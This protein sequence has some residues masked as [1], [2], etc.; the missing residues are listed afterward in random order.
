MPLPPQVKKLASY[1]YR[2]IPLPYHY[3]R[4]YREIAAFLDDTRG[5]SEERLQEYQLERVKHIVDHAYQNTRFY[6][7]LYDRVGYK[8]GDISTF[9][10]F[11]KLPTIDRSD[12]LARGEDF[13]ARDFESYQ[14]KLTYT[15][16]TSGAPL[17][18]YRSRDTELHRRASSWRW[19]RIGGTDHYRP[20]VDFAAGVD[21]PDD[22]QMFYW[23][24]RENIWHLN[25]KLR[26]RQHIT[27]IFQ[28]I[29]RI[30][31]AALTGAPSTIML[32]AQLAL[33]AGLPPYTS[34]AV[35]T[36]GELLKRTITDKIE[37][38]FGQTLRDA[39]GNRE[40]SLS[41][42][43]YEYGGD[44]FVNAE[45]CRVELL[46]ETGAVVG[47]GESGEVCST[48][49]INEAFP[50]IRYRTADIAEDRGVQQ[51]AGFNRRAI[52]PLVGRQRDIILTPDGLM[53]VNLIHNLGNFDMT[54]IRN[55]VI[56]QYTI[57]E[58]EVQLCPAPGFRQGD[59][60]AVFV[61]EMT[62]QL[63]DNMRFVVKYIDEL[64]ITNND[65]IKF[66]DSPLAREYLEKNR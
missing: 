52:K 43:Q 63:P 46:D 38:F 60:E 18:I 2:A 62:R 48:S 47:P 24:A 42:Y 66:V 8:P 12:A 11:Q 54:L 10:D 16:G 7:E 45:T 65:K 3:G 14:P 6:R 59:H 27:E 25:K 57:D 49:L 32:I 5:W 22:S 36:T 26:N 28:A 64:P 31:P 39:F 1:A 17:R 20:T 50:F 61:A 13:K 4:R 29:E 35:F 51:V 37:M 41:S 44:Y 9:E 56:R 55:F 19:R 33:E 15:S 34:A 21:I 30:K 23:N 53:N 58:L 40:N